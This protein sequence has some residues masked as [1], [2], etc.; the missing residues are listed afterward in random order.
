MVSA[1]K[2]ARIRKLAQKAQRREGSRLA[3]QMDPVDLSRPGTDED[4]EEDR[5]ILF[6]PRS[7]REEQ[8]PPVPNTVQA[9][10]D[11]EIMNM[12]KT[13]NGAIASVSQDTARIWRASDQLRADNITRDKA[14]ADLSAMVKEYGSPPAP[15]RPHPVIRT[16]VLDEDGNLCVAD[17]GITWAGN[18]TF[19]HGVRVVGPGP[20]RPSGIGPAMSTPYQPT[21]DHDLENTSMTAQPPTPSTPLTVPDAEIQLRRPPQEIRQGYRPAAPIQRFNNKSLNWPTSMGGARIRGRCNW[22]PTWTRPP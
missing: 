14:L 8:S 1:A 22:C 9:A 12:V 21:R 19:L 4:E 11:C 16:D 18:E 6:V 17:I 20:P 5:E 10:S 15:T 2:R 3:H 7:E 13:L